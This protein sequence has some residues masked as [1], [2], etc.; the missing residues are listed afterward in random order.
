MNKQ[1]TKEAV[2]IKL[3]LGCGFRTV[4]GFINIDN[5][6]EICGVRPD[7]VLDITTGLPYPDNSVEEVR[8]GDILEHIP[9]S[10]VVFVIEEIWRVLKHNGRFEHYTPS[11]DGRG[12]FQDPTHVS[13]WNI[14]SWLYYVDDEHRNLY[15][16]KAK[17]VIEDMHDM[18][19]DSF[20]HIVHTHG[21][22]RAQK[23]A[24]YAS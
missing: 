23:E 10:K 12:A 9:L 20:R 16:I 24:P 11:T 18:M 19:T 4:N 6:E 2:P 14:N 3:N 15:G 22:L 17:F 5:R 21:V 8:A 1:E 13:Y 7:L